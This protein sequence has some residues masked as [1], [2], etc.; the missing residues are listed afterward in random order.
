MTALCARQQ[1]MMEGIVRTNQ[2]PSRYILSIFA[3]RKRIRATHAACH[4]VAPS[5]ERQQAYTND[6]V[7]AIRSNNVPRLREMLEDG[8]SFDACNSNGETL[9]H[10]ACRRSKMETIQFL[11]EE[12]LVP[13][14]VT[15]SMGRTPLHDVCWRPRPDVKLMAF[16]I[17]CVGPDMIIAEDMRGHNCF[18]YCRKGDWSEWTTFLQ[19]HSEF[20]LL[21]AAL[22]DRMF[23]D[24]D[25]DNKH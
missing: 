15:D 17:R 9:L 18:D 7:R 24:D 14:N 2:S 1:P 22:H 6:A 25:A 19:Q 23:G 21:R 5:V 16:L 20:L 13:V 11:I 12:A 4:K 8:L 10:L 3:E